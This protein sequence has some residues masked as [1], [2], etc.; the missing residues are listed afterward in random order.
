MPKHVTSRIVFD[1]TI[2]KMEEIFESFNSF[3]E[4]EAGYT[5]NGDLRF[6]E[7]GQEM[8]YGFLNLKTGVFSR[9]GEENVQGVP[10]GYVVDITPAYNHFP[11][12]N[13]VIPQPENIFNGDLSMS[14]KE[15][16]IKNGTPNW[17]DWNCENWGTKWNSYSLKKVSWNTY[18]FDTAWSG[19]PGIIQRISELFPDVKINYLYADE[20]SGSNTGVYEFLGGDVVSEEL[21]ESGSHRGYEIYL[22]LNPDCDYIKLIDGVYQYV[23]E[24]DE[25]Y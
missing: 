25:D 7:K 17:Y 16:L 6:K 4:A 24:D 20:D 9:R 3:N 8:S 12:F 14:K 1:C 19:V 22:M 10:E 11:D 18:E 15:E 21:P 23:D 13:K 5:W 2:E